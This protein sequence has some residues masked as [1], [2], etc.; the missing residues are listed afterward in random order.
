MAKPVTRNKKEFVDLLKEGT[1]LN[2]A[3]AI[4]QTLLIK[5][6]ISKQPGSIRAMLFQVASNNYIW[7]EVQKVA[8]ERIW[9]AFVNCSQDDK[10]N[11]RQTEEMTPSINAMKKNIRKK[12]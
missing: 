10:N 1:I 11:W 2:N 3:R 8:I 6:V 4:D 12:I 7:N 9:V 5:I